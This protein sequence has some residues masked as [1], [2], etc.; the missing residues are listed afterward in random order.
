MPIRTL[1]VE[2]EGL[3]RDLLAI[4]FGNA[5]EI[6]VVGSVS[7][8]ESALR[9]ASELKPDVILMDIELGSGKNGIEV[10]RAIRQERPGTGIVLLS[11]HNT[12]QYLQAIPEREAAGWSYL[13]KQSVS[14]VTNLVRVI[15]GAAMGLMI[16]DP[17]INRSLAPRQDSRIGRLTPRRLEVLRLVAEGYSNAVIAQRMFLSDKSV[18]NH[19]TAV[20]QE[21]GIHQENEPVHPRVKA[22]LIYLNET[23]LSQPSPVRSGG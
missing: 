5:P 14:D 13:L 12:R 18:E 6:E 2:D 16:L 15:Q 9:A 11:N 23:Q 7:D 17:A 8:G 3:Y 1:I 22:V 20:Y 21:L 10:G 19:M 4:A